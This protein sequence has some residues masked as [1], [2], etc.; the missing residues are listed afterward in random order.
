MTYP[1]K[2]EANG[3]IYDINTDYQIALDCFKAIEDD[4]I[5]DTE[6][7]LAIITLLLGKNVNANDYEICLEKCAV[8]L[9]CGKKENDDIDKADMDY[10]QDETYIRASIRQCY[11]LNLNKE[12]YIHWWEYNELIEGLTE[13]TVLNKRRELRNLDLNE[14]QDEKY[15]KELKKAQEKIALKKKIIPLTD[16]QQKSVENFYKLTGIKR[17]E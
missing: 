16:K 10:F 17:K 5:N 6:R 14:I 8:Y 15:R 11:H 12:K 7:A 3:R 4:A 2:I 1:T 13:E 9:R